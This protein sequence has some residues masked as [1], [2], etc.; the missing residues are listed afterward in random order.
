MAEMHPRGGLL[1]LETNLFICRQLL[2]SENIDKALQGTAEYIL[3]L[4]DFSFAAISTEDH[5][6]GCMSMNALAS[7]KNVANFLRGIKYE[8]G[9]SKF[10]D[11]WIGGIFSF[12]KPVVMPKHELESSLAK[13][14]GEGLISAE[15][16][17][18][19]LSVSKNSSSL[20]T[21]FFG[22]RKRCGDPFMMLIVAADRE[23]SATETEMIDR[24]ADIMALAVERRFEIETLD[25]KLTRYKA[26]VDSKEHA[27][28]L[29]INGRLEFFSGRLPELLGV[30]ADELVGKRIEDY[31]HPDDSAD[32]RKMFEAFMDKDS[33][34]AKKYYHIYRLAGGDEVEMQIHL[35]EFRGGKAIRGTMENVS[36]RSM[37]E[38]TAMEAKHIESMARLAGGVAHDFNN[39][40]GA[41]IGYA[42]LIRNSLPRNDERARQLMKIEEAGARANRLTRQLLSMSRKGN[43][44]LE[45][46]DIREIMDRVTR[47]CLLPMDHISLTSRC[48][49][50]LLNVEGDPSQLYEA[51]LNVCMNARESMPA[52]GKID[53]MVENDRID[54][55]H[56]VFTDGMKTGEYVR[57][58]VRDA[59]PGMDPTVLRRVTEPFFTTRQD[60]SHRGLGLPA[61]IG[62]VEGH[63]G[64]MYLTSRP[65]SGT[66]V[67]IYLP[68]TDKA[69]KESTRKSHEGM[70][71]CRVLVVDDEEII[72][73]LATD[74]LGRL[75][76]DVLTAGSGQKAIELLGREKVDLVFLDLLM[77]E[78][79][80]QEAFYRI[81]ETAP[82][83]PV[84]ISS[85]Y[86]EDSVIRGLLD[87]GAVSFLR[88]PYRLQ[89]MADVLREALGVAGYNARKGG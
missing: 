65:G 86:S 72:L 21:I 69:Q 43:Y 36:Q 84:I 1:G 71:G 24:I 45:V 19:S 30:S 38:K 14:A 61:A 35:I 52:G 31:L 88:K 47:S 33:I 68:V 26:L 29:L 58:S 44:A 15:A 46:I 23:I 62:I 64:K 42:S 81:R 37:L 34:S 78:M 74:M 85:G 51:L 28:F 59:G 49:A 73:D 22:R 10:I 41:M 27:F 32:L 54:K 57:I 75:G 3:E 2:E 82:D 70:G 79:S 7:R 25:R 80:G 56:E 13:F 66:E 17:S 5:S 63:K 18:A 9:R 83:L 12:E 48:D 39:L 11:E 67:V 6:G 76:Y 89:D 53:I 55:T 20:S 50:L 77:P 16:F 8:Y 60:R 4:F 87:E 40:I